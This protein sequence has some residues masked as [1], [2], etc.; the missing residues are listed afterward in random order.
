MVSVSERVLNLWPRATQVLLELDVVEDLAV[1]GDPDGIVLVAHGLGA[2]GEVDDAESR[3]GESSAGL[4][5]DAVRV[6]AAVVERPDRRR[7]QARGAAPRRAGRNIRR[8]RTYQWLN[9]ISFVAVFVP[10]RLRGSVKRS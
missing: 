10:S 1:E 3:V 8:F 9:A 4:E 6:G 2:A 7:R 5:V